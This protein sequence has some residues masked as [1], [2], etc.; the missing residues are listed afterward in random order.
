MRTFIATQCVVRWEG[1]LFSHFQTLFLSSLI[2]G[3]SMPQE[4]SSHISSLLM[5]YTHMYT[6]NDS[7]IIL[8]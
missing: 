3:Y 1:G 8:F 2:G 5:V 7:T 4:M 6:G